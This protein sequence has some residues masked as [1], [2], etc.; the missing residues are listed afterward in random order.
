MDFREFCANANRKYTKEYFRQ[1]ALLKIILRN[2]SERI[3]RSDEPVE[4]KLDSWD[5]VPLE[6]D[7]PIYMGRLQDDY[8]AVT[9]ELQRIGSNCFTCSFGNTVLGTSY[10]SL[11]SHII[12]D[13]C[14]KFAEMVSIRR[15]KRMHIQEKRDKRIE[16][17]VKISCGRIYNQ[18]DKSPGSRLIVSNPSDW[19]YSEMF[20]A[21]SKIEELSEGCLKCYLDNMIIGKHPGPKFISCRIMKEM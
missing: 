12:D 5:R 19:K 10:I 3:I 20:E 14:P 7:L 18:L 2:F 11:E 9:Q 15:Q 21:C 1:R 8:E 17:I 16:Q 4:Y 6:N 13:S